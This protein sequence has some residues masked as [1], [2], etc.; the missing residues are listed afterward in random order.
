[1]RRFAPLAVAVVL[2]AGCTHTQVLERTAPPETYQAANET[3]AG[4]DAEVLTRRGEIFRWYDVR[5]AP[6][7][8]SGLPLATGAAA[9]RPWIPTEQ[10]ARGAPSRAP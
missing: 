6:D 2:L 3:T 4:R 5:L 10:L 7:S 9:A 8:T 1:M